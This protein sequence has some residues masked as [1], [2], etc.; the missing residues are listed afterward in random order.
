MLE[1]CRPL[2]C[3]TP[4][5]GVGG[6]S[7]DVRSTDMAVHQYLLD[8]GLNLALEGN[9]RLVDQ[10][11][12]HQVAPA[13]NSA[14]AHDVYSTSPAGPTSRGGCRSLSHNNLLAQPRGRPLTSP[15]CSS[16]L[17]SAA[18]F[19]R[20]NCSLGTFWSVQQPAHGS[21]FLGSSP[22]ATTRLRTESLRVRRR[23]GLAS[24]ERTWFG[25]CR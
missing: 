1:P 23:V 9:R 22:L 3:G 7:L 2:D 21:S 17:L 15:E 19:L 5:N 12:A 18:E 16:S 20:R 24:S 10:M 13:A 8:T 6:R 25:G 4:A 14:G 11:K